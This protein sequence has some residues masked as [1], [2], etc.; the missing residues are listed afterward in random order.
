[1]FNSFSGWRLWHLEI[2]DTEDDPARRPDEDYSL[3]Q[4]FNG[5]ERAPTEQE[6][7]EELGLDA[8]EEIA[9]RQSMRSGDTAESAAVRAFV[10]VSLAY[11]A[12]RM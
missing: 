8:P 3:Q 2:P 6:M 4:P 5:R 1:M 9:L 12:F 11:R 7:R 10:W